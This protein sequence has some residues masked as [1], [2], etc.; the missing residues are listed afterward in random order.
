MSEPI[1]RD[2]LERLKTLA[3][4]IVLVNEGAI[5]SDPPPTDVVAE[6]LRALLS[7]YEAQEKEIEKLKAEV[8]SCDGHGYLREEI[9]RLRWLIVAAEAVVWAE[10]SDSQIGQALLAEA[11]R[12]REEEGRE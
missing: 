9:K 2:V 6:Q 3:D 1:G 11:R 4:W 5:Q 10:G 8:A 12:I 7:A